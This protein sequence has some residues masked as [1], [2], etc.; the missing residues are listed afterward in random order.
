MGGG[1]I[2]AL[3]G[4]WMAS[5]TIATIVNDAFSLVTPNTF[6]LMAFLMCALVSVLIG[7]S[8]GTLSVIGLPLIIIARSGQINLQ[9]VAGAI[10]AGIYV[11]DRCSPLSSSASLVAAVTNTSLFDNLRTMLKTGA[12]PFILASA[13]YGWLSWRYP[14]SHLNTSLLTQLQANFTIAWWQLIPAAIVLGMALLRRPLIES[15]VISI[16]SAL[17]LGYFLQGTDWSTMLGAMIMGFHPAGAHPV[18]GGGIISML[19]A[20]LVV[21]IS[22]GLAGVLN[23]T[24]GLHQLQRL[25]NRPKLTSRRR[26]SITALVSLATSGFGCNQSVAI[27]LTNTLMKPSYH[28][29]G[30]ALAS[31]IENTAIVIAPLV[32]WNIAVF[33]PMSLLGVDFASYLPFALFLWLVPL[34]GWGLRR[35]SNKLNESENPFPGK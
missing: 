31:D 33:V 22:C 10:I 5:G 14:I 20:I 26:F 23:M 11:G 32:P 29:E 8:F 35:K 4:V 13:G 7:T 21:T 17:C 25:V 3:I 9:M 2:G 19:S 18:S 30:P 28:D 24:D 1:Q 12:M 27:I 34:C 15:I 6:V 16:I